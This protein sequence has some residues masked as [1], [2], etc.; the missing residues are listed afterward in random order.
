M[1]K[2]WIILLSWVRY[3][4]RIRFYKRISYM[5]L[6]DAFKKITLIFGMDF[7]KALPDKFDIYEH[8]EP[9]MGYGSFHPDHLHQWYNEE[10]LPNKSLI[11]I[12]KNIQSPKQPALT[13]ICEFNPRAFLLNKRIV[14]IPYSLGCLRMKEHF[15]YG[16][17]SVSIILPEAIGSWPAIW[18]AAAD[19]Y[20]PEIDLL[21]GYN[22]KGGY[23]WCGLNNVRLESNLWPTKDIHGNIIQAGA[24]KHPVPFDVTKKALD[25]WFVRTRTEMKLYYDGYLVR[26]INDRDIMK[27]YEDVPMILIL[28][29]GILQNN[30]KKDVYLEFSIKKLSVTRWD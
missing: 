23:K 28:G 1:K 3:F 13:L 21:E 17:I 22:R 29:N 18:M 20:P 16:L 15:I 10:T 25:I 27:F 6:S 24:I 26:H 19:K 30:P 14:R 7:T 4:F 9:G 5:E 2:Y 12:N 11:F 8:F